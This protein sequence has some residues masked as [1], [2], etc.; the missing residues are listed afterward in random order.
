MPILA[1]TSTPQVSI[2]RN[3]TIILL[4]IVLLFYPRITI[5]TRSIFG[6]HQLNL[7][8]DHFL[9]LQLIVFHLIDFSEI[10]DQNQ[11]HSVPRYGSTYPQF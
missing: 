9:R 5:E 11:V 4:I 3:F 7:P 10:T 2:L 8:I 6:A 1:P